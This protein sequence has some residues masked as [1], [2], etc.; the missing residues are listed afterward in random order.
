[1]Y[2]ITFGGVRVTIIAM[3]TQ[4]YNLR[5]LLRWVSLPTTRRYWIVLMQ[6]YAAD[7]NTTYLDL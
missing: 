7:N 4:Q 1:M 5:V 3:D 2:N 6:M